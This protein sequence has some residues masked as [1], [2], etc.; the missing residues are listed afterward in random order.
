MLWAFGISGPPGTSGAEACHPICPVALAL[1]SYTGNPSQAP[2]STP[3]ADGDWST[4]MPPE[5]RVMSSQCPTKNTTRLCSEVRNTRWSKIRS[6][7]G[8]D[9]ADCLRIWIS[10]IRGKVGKQYL[11]KHLQC[12]HVRESITVLR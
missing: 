6:C 12:L 5:V 1:R 3:F 7:R 2:C 9:L 8:P 10:P 4:G 11:K